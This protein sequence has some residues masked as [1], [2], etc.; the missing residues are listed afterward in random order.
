MAGAI[1]S[2]ARVTLRKDFRRIDPA[3][4]RV[5][6]LEGGPRILP[7]FS[8]E[9]SRKAQDRLTR[10]GVEVRTGAQVEHVDDKG[11]I[12]AGQRIASRTVLWTA[13]VQPSP[14]GRGCRP[15]PIAPGGSRSCPT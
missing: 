2:M 10:M 6:L 8:E 9:L 13:G 3:L 7:S 14:A 11:V 5:I 12:V 15:R 4:T 1:A